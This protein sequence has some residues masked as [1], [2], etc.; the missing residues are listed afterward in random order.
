MGSAVAR[1][2][3]QL[4]GQFQGHGQVRVG[5]VQP[6]GG[7][8]L[9]QRLLA[10]RAPAGLRQLGGHVLRQAHGAADLADRAAGAVADDGGANRRPFAAVALVQVLDHLFAPLM[11]E[12]DVDIW[13]FAAILGDEAFEQQVVF[14][15]VHGGDAQHVA[16]RRIGRRAAPLAQDAAAAGEPH[17]LMH[18]EKIGRVVELLDQGQL[19][20]HLGAGGGVAAAGVHRLGHAGGQRLLRGAAGFHQLIGIFVAELVERKAARGVQDTKGVGDGVG[21]VAEQPRHFGGGFEVAFAIGFGGETQ[22]VDTG[23]KAD[24]GEDIGQAAA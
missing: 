14:G 8:Q 5:R 16:D 9:G 10:A 11:L 3:L 13:W 1:E 22:R 20:R 21:V 2:I 19:I 17:D 24:G 18:R 15:R 4:L 6:L 12:I 23:A 7:G